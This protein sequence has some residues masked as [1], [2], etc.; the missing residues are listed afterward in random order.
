MLHQNNHNSRELPSTMLD[1]NNISSWEQAYDQYAPMMYGTILNMT[2]DET[3]A[4]DILQEV[5]LDFTKKNIL[6]V[7]STTLLLRLLRHTYKFTIKWL[8]IRGLVPKNLQPADPNYPHINLFFFQ[9]INLKQVAQKNDIDEKDIQKK[10][11][12]EFNKLRTRSH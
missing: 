12:A 1:K 8:E 11:R 7:I 5:F 3:L 9:E 4:C 6:P 10:L 2:H